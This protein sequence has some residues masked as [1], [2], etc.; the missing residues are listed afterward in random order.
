MKMIN[1][2]CKAGDNAL[3]KLNDKYA[4][5]HVARQFSIEHQQFKQGLPMY[6]QKQE[7]LDM[8]HAAQCVVLRGGTGIG[9]SPSDTLLIHNPHAIDDVAYLAATYL[10]CLL[11][12]HGIT[13][14]SIVILLHMCPSR[15]HHKPYARHTVNRVKPVCSASMQ[16]PC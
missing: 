5:E 15:Y 3:P 16:Q 7:F 11:T 6:A 12:V 13:N 9:K 4:L 8:L 2:L 1:Y 14:S 10:C